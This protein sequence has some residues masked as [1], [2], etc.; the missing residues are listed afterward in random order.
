MKPTHQIYLSLGSNLGDRLHYLAAATEQLES[1]GMKVMDASGIYESGSWG[2]SSSN[3]FLNQ[4]LKMATVMQ[5]EELLQTIG[6][7]EQNLDRV[8][9]RTNGYQDRTI[10]I[11]ILF[12]DQMVLNTPALRLPHPEIPNRRF[13]LVPMTELAPEFSDPETGRD[14]QTLLNECNDEMIVMRYKSL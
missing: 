5:P 2:Y 4:V 9:G 11:D 6:K 8:R 3:P 12:F 14:M 10:D 1:A 13:I 7:I